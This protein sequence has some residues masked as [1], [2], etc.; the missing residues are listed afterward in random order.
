MRVYFRIVRAAHEG[1]TV[2]SPLSSA[3]PAPVS[4][5][6]DCRWGVSDGDGGGESASSEPQTPEVGLIYLE[7]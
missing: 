1:S 6:S 5:V 2:V 7:N 4:G 3:G